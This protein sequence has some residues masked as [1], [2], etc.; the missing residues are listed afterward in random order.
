MSKLHLITTTLVHKTLS[1]LSTPLSSDHQQQSYNL[2]NIGSAAAPCLH[3]GDSVFSSEPTQFPRK[4]N[5]LRRRL[6][7]SF[8]LETLTSRISRLRPNLSFNCTNSNAT[9]T[10]G[11]IFLDCKTHDHPSHSHSSSNRII[12][13]K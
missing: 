9:A 5:G 2:G 4:S 6:I 3:C 11:T 8:Q 12:I 13:V 7:F 10:V 1:C